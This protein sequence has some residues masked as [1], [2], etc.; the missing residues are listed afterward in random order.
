MADLG[1]SWGC[2]VKYQLDIPMPSMSLSIPLLLMSLSISMPLMSLS[3]AL[4]LMSLSIHPRFLIPLSTPMLLVSPSIPVPSMSLFCPRGD[5]AHSGAWSGVRC[6]LT[7][8]RQSV[9]YRSHF[10]PLLLWIPCS[11]WD[12]GQAEHSLGRGGTG[13][14]RERILKEFR[15]QIIGI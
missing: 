13:A 3:I 5:G 10:I 8:A 7:T 11:C 6:T 4:S 15:Q 14:G 9:V 1:W 2:S 12:A